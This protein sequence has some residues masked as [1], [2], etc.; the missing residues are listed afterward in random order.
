MHNHLHSRQVL[1]NLI[2]GLFCLMSYCLSTALLGLLLAH[3]CFCYPPPYLHNESLVSMHQ[4]TFTYHAMLC[5]WLAFQESCRDK[6]SMSN[7]REKELMLARCTGKVKKTASLLLSNE[8]TIYC[9]PI[10]SCECFWAL[11][12]LPGKACFS[13]E[14]QSIFYSTDY[15]A[16]NVLWH[17]KCGQL[18]ALHMKVNAWLIIIIN[19]LHVANVPWNGYRMS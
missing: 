3:G 13:K 5:Y 6:W 1:A 18:A 12:L 8:Q 10:T 17:T 15:L 16:D 11:S 7:I 19:Q 4:F 14:P 2:A 9:S